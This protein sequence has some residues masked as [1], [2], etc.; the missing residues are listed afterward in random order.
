[1]VKIRQFLA[2]KDVVFTLERSG[3]DAVGAIAQ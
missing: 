2:L 3:I 1:M